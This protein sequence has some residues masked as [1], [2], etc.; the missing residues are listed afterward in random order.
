MKP[1]RIDSFDAYDWT[2]I[3]WASRAEGHNMVH[4]L[5]EEFHAGVNRFDAVGELLCAH[6]LDQVVIAVAGLNQEPDPLYTQAGRI[7]RLYVLPRFRGKGL[8]RAL[9]DE[10]AQ[11][12]LP[13]FDR[14]TV[15]VGKLDARGFYEHLGFMPVQHACITHIKELRHHVCVPW[16][17]I[18]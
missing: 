13:H 3:L 2:E 10:L 1:K 14:L 17:R 5:V 4:R 12:A 7:R 9:I 6:F 16:N 15:N 11:C 18:M 8:A